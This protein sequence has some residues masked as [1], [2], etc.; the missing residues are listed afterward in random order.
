MRIGDLYNRGGLRG[1]VINVDASGRHGL[2][3]SLNKHHC[4]WYQGSSDVRTGA[5]DPFNGK[6]N[7][8]YVLNHYGSYHYPAFGWCESLGEGWYLPAIGELRPLCEPANLNAVERTL[9]S[10]GE[11]LFSGRN[12]ADLYLSST[13]G[14]CYGTY[15]TDHTMVQV[16]CVSERG[17]SISSDTKRSDYEYARAVH[18]F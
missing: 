9:R 2:I 6:I 13:E 4:Q 8:D 7:Q 10:Y 1:V 17:G 3:M 5:R 14:D 18:R 12:N 16:F 11:P 15:D